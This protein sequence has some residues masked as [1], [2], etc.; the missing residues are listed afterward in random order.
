M[1]LPSIIQRLFEK[2]GF[3]TFLRK[4][5]IPNHA[6][7]H[8][9]GGRDALQID[10]SQIVS[11]VMALSRMPETVKERSVTVNSQKELFELTTDR[12]QNGDDV[13]VKES[14]IWYKVKDDS[15]LNS[16]AGY[17]IIGSSRVASNGNA[18]QS[19]STLRLANPV[20][21]K[22]KGFDT[23]SQP[24]DGSSD[25]TITI[26]S[27]D[28][29]LLK[30][31]ASNNIVRHISSDSVV[32][33]SDKGTLFCCNGNKVMLYLDDNGMENGW[34]CYIK[35]RTGSM[36]KIKPMSSNLIDEKQ[37]LDLNPLMSVHVFFDGVNF[38]TIES[39]PIITTD[40]S[41]DEFQT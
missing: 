31:V 23:T 24:W 18:I 9:K 38:V 12:V 22:L 15:R 39:T 16:L 8:Q 1:A 41:G 26:N 36:C 10:A 32:K 21:I 5:I 27:I 2:A 20:Y 34:N 11:G 25:L 37:E 35:N 6:D 14:G 13:L 17:Q 19:N 7:I 28:N 3:G 29:D 30:S 40:T 4:E 33:Y